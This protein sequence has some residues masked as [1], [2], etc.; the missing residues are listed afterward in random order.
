MKKLTANSNEFNTTDINGV[1]FSSYKFVVDVIVVF[2]FSS[3]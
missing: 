2:D 3:K 1:R